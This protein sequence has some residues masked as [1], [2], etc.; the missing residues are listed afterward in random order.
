VPSG[1][2][3]CWYFTHPYL[4]WRPIA[5]ERHEISDVM[6]TQ[7]KSAFSGLQFRRSQYGSIFIRLT[8]I[9]SETR[10]MSQNSYEIW[11]YSSSRSSKVIDLG[12]SGKTICDFLLVINCN[13]SRVKP[14]FVILTSGHSDAQGWASECPDV[15]NY[16][17][18]LNPVWHRMLYGCTHMATVGVKGLKCYNFTADRC[19]C[20]RLVL[21]GHRMTCS[22]LS[23]D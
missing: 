23:G 15:K 5:A 21:N 6:Y 9:A 8:V 12:V 20:W 2:W 13:F 7:L 19:W 1:N 11:P 17:S 22:V 3:Y 16:K 14:W 4:V 10:E 18:R